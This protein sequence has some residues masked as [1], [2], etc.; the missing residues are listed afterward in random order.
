MRACLLVLLMACGGEQPA[1]AP[2]EAP[3][4]EAAKAPASPADYAEV[5]KKIAA[6]P[7]DKAAILEEHQ[8]TED[9]WAQALFDIASDEA[10]AAE[11]AAAYGG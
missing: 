3:T 2:E 7:A 11:Y 8:L 6:N 4:E 10:K 5:A 9:A 1:E